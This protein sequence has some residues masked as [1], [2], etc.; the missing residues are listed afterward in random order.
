MLDNISALLQ[1]APFFRIPQAAASRLMQDTSGADFP[2]SCRNAASST[3]LV[4]FFD[5]PSSSQMATD[6]FAT[7]L[8]CPYV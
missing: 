4:C 5:M 8:E 7:L 2:I 6:N 3:S 1:G